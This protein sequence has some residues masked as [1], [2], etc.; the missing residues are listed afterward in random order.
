M[1]LNQPIVGM[2][3]HP[4][5]GYWFVAADGGVFSFPAD[6][7]RF[8][9]SLG[10]RTLPAPVVA[11]ASTATGNGYWLLGRDGKLYPFGDAR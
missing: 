2:T 3:A 4:K 6:P 7:R 9:G 8:H 11:M 10:D 1:R 5:G